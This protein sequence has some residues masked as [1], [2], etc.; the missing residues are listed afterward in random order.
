MLN[1]NVK[2][3]CI[4]AINANT[5]SNKIKKECKR[6]DIYSG[7]TINVYIQS[8]KTARIYGF[9]AQNMTASESPLKLFSEKNR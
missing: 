1:M 2:Q 5:Q 9:S 6:D 4:I 8:S 3:I 7:W